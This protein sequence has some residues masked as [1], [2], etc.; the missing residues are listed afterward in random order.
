M[1]CVVVVLILF[2]SQ[3]FVFVSRKALA[4]GECLEDTRQVHAASGLRLTLVTR[5]KVDLQPAF[6]DQTSEAGSRA[7]GEIFAEDHVVDAALGVHE[8]AMAMSPQDRFTFLTQW[9]LPNDAHTSLRLNLAFSP[10]YPS[11]AEGEPIEAGDQRISTGGE[12]ICPAVDLLD[13]ATQLNKLALVRTAVA[14]IKPRNRLEEKQL[15]AFRCL[16]ELAANNRDDALADCD[17][18][19]KLT[20]AS[21]PH[22]SQ[23]RADEMLLML[24]ASTTPELK[25][26][27]ADYVRQVL[28]P[29][30]WPTYMDVWSRQFTRLAFRMTPAMIEDLTSK[31]LEEIPSIVDAPKFWTPVTYPLAARRGV[32]MPPA[33]WLFTRSQVINV[34]NHGDDAVY[35]NMPLLGD[36]TLEADATVS[37]WREAEM[38][39]G[40]RWVGTAHQA[41]LHSVG[42]VRRKIGDFKSERPTTRMDHW[43]RHRTNIKSQTADVSLDG[44]KVQQDTFGKIRD[45]WIGIRSRHLNEGGA[46]NVLISGSPT[47]PETIDLIGPGLDSWFDYYAV[48]DPWEQLTWSLN[49]DEIVGRRFPASDHGTMNEKALY[50]HRPMLED[51]TIEYEFYYE[52]GAKCAHPAID[53]MCFILN[54]DFVGLHQLTDGIYDQT[55]A[56]PANLTSLSPRSIPL[57][58]KQ[59]GWNR[60]QV[61]LRG[62]VI[63]LSL[64][65]E[66]IA[67][68]TLP[69]T[70]QRFF[71][72]FH[73]ADQEGLR[74]RNIRWTGSWRRTLPTTDEDELAGSQSDFLDKDRDHLNA[75]FQHNFSTH[76]LPPELF[77]LASGEWEKDVS[78]TKSGLLMK[79]VT[80]RV[81]SVSLGYTIGGDFD[82]YARYTAFQ[83]AAE[84]GGARLMTRL[85]SPALHEV[86]GGRKH[87]IHSCA[88]PTRAR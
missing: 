43:Y 8:R 21:D 47:I 12:I 52:A 24:K 35:F 20:N 86:I 77:R 29:E 82:I 63:T 59:D 76:G 84:G 2:G 10:T 54:N 39:V 53:R 56:D 51:G 16:F 3:A 34:A 62:D 69:A 79:A 42:T 48:E 68:Q 80:T 65:G 71:G 83:G 32:G 13:T 36:L 7:L 37:N 5:T 19:L 81:S 61:S 49:D 44:N 18:F 38:I 70:N 40:A 50:Y 15:A 75:L 67:E 72:L 9:V 11:Q 33:Q 1:C 60:M 45:P 27:I 6:A 4:A 85:Q 73:Y 22:N 46:R 88:P 55:S 30:R 25:E 41:D 23:Y 66:R 87:M 78:L 17:A 14:K 74:V 57:P 64:N 28:V 26:A 58:L 31:T